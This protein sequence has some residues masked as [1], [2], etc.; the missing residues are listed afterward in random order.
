MNCCSNCFSARIARYAIYPLKKINTAITSIHQGIL[1][2]ITTPPC[3]ISPLVHLYDLKINHM[4]KNCFKFLSPVLRVLFDWNFKISIREKLSQIVS[5]QNTE[6]S[7]RK[8]FSRIV[9]E[10]NSEISIRETT[11]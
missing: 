2:N 1:N 8:K 11:S 7:I 4:L 9:S 5:E 3:P 6:I 10:R